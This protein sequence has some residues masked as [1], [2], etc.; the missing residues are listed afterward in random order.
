MTWLWL[1]ALLLAT[2]GAL[3]WWM[4][5]SV[6]VRT[7]LPRGSV[8]YS[9]TG[10]EEAVEAPLRSHRYGLVGRPDYL[11]VRE[12]KGRKVIVPVEVKSRRTPNPPHPGHALQ[13]GAYCLLVEEAYGVEVGYGLLRYADA[14]QPVPFTPALRAAV[15]Q[16][17]AEI[18]AARAADDVPRDHNVAALHPLRL[19]SRLRPGT[20]LLAATQRRKDA[21]KSNC[22]KSH[23]VHGN[24]GK[25]CRPKS[26][27]FTA[28]PCTKWLFL[29]LLFF[30]SLRLCVAASR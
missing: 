7:G 19:S 20:H 22:K 1:A 10:A 5:R 3:L 17:A 13:L 16:A 26:R 29:Q 6:R 30:A 4:G 8:L 23:L 27:A 24:C 25:S 28:V 14:T 11:L 15:L 12:E 21:K 18:R 2:T 9:D